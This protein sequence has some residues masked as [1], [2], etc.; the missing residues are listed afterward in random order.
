[1]S[2]SKRDKVI[3]ACLAALLLLGAY[4]RTDGGFFS[5]SSSNSPKEE[6]SRVYSKSNDTEEEKK[7][8]VDIVGAVENSGVISLPE[9]ARV[10]EALEKAAPEEKADLDRIKRARPLIDGEK[11]RVP[12]QEEESEDRE[13]NTRSNGGKININQASLEDLTELGGIG[14][15]KA[16]SII[17]Y[18]EEQGYFQELEE[19]KKISGIGAATFESIKD[20][21]TLY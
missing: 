4:L 13:K 20:S 16:R 2:L 6:E 8:Y 21:I 3:L 15:V 18:R 11:I 17:D 1:L 10:F 9:G 19:I 14:E 5:D 12:Y 7:I